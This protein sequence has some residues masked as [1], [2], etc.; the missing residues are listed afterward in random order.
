VASGSQHGT[1]VPFREITH[2]RF[3][4]GIGRKLGMLKPQFLSIYDETSTPGTATR[5]DFGV[6]SGYTAAAA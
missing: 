6:I 1:A 5:Q 4:I 2:I 3:G